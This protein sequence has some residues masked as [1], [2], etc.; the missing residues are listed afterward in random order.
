MNDLSFSVFPFLHI[1]KNYDNL[2]NN[3]DFFLAENNG[4]LTIVYNLL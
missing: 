2:S 1:G 4:S 3:F